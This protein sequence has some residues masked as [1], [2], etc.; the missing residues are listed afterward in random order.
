[1][2]GPTTSTATDMKAIIQ[3]RYG[4]ADGWALERLARPTPRADKVLIRVR[5]AGLDRGVWHLMEGKPLVVR[6][7]FGLRRPRNPVPGF[8]VAGVVEA[9]GNKVTAFSPGDEVLGIGKGTF[10]EYAVAKAE[11]LVPKPAN[12]TFEQ[13]AV[14]S[15]SGITALQA[16]DQQAKVQA[17]DKVLILGASG[18]VGAF[19]VQIAKAR[20]ARV[21]GVCSPAKADFVH[22][23]GAELTIDYHHQDVAQM[24]ERY[25]VIIDLG[26]N[27]PLSQI[28]KALASDG[29]LVLVGGDEG[30]AWIGG[31]DRNLRAAIL[32]RFT[33]QRLAW[34][35]SGENK[36]DIAAVAHLAATGVIEVPLDQ[37]FPLAQAPQAMHYLVDGQVQ[38]KL[39]ISIL[40]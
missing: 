26:G 31:I 36:E 29:T 12:L 34:F 21:T 19:V 13:A 25:D 9:V 3:R 30:D 5:A 23:L 16:V 17:D 8:D 38:G 28:R 35:L 33:D 14:L 39:A 4:S 40:G 27:R 22:S 37:T 24:D 32:S 10:A 2:T 7:A 20:G 1:M 6:L 15:I 18:G 11:K